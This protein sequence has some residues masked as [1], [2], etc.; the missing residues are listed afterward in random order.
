MSRSRVIFFAIIGAALLLVVFS[1]II[2]PAIQTRTGEQ[3]ATATA[4]YQ[5]T[6]LVT[7]RVNYETSKELWFRAAVSLFQQAN[8]NI[9]I[10]MMPQGSMQGYQTLSQVRDT[11][12]TC[13]TTLIFWR[14]TRPPALFK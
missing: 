10:D 2:A 12:M 7:I 11:A 5:K 3:N 14:Y 9:K 1:I 13:L 6:N 8:P 4:Q